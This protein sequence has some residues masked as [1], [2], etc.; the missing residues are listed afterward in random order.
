[1]SSRDIEEIGKRKARARQEWTEALSGEDASKS[2]SWQ[3][4]F[5][6]LTGKGDFGLPERQARLLLADLKAKF[7][8]I[9][10]WGGAEEH[11]EE[12][13]QPVVA[14]AVIFQAGCARKPDDFIPDPTFPGYAINHNL[15]V[16]AI[17]GKGKRCGKPLAMLR[18]WHLRRGEWIFQFGYRLTFGGGRKFVSMRAIAIR[19]NDLERQ[20]K[21]VAEVGGGGR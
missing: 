13:P 7:A 4:V 12:A 18:K 21:A 8:G 15:E 6:S 3:E 20:R 9:P 19:R 16:M 14:G 5:E 10:E 2:F 1:M 11:V 17:N